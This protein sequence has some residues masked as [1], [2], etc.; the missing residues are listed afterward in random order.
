MS[1]LL[2]IKKID[3]FYNPKLV[4]IMGKDGK[5]FLVKTDLK[6]KCKYSKERVIL[7]LIF[8]QSV[9]AS[10]PEFRKRPQKLGMPLMPA[11]GLC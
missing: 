5:P 4:Y 11:Y 7:Q 9:S 3:Q 6:K 8:N 1:E 2:N 10:G